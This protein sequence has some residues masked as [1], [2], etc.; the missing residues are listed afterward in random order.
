MSK[1]F[2]KVCHSLLLRNLKQCNVSGRHLNWFNAYLTNRKQRVTV[3]GETSTEVLVSSGVPQGSLLDLL[4]FL[5]FVN[6][7]P[8]RCSSSNVACF[9][10]DT[11]IYK[12]IDSVG[13]SKALQHDLDRPYGLVYINI[14]PVQ[15]AKMQVSAYN[16]K[17]KSY[18]AAIF[19]E[20]VRLRRYSS[21]ERFWCVDL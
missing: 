3:S 19:Y 14:P 21:R 8:D 17:E 18:R 12:L 6:N 13:D 5:L 4:L 10:D 7:L 2:D 11:R 20:R 15:P 16:K 9:A 1:A